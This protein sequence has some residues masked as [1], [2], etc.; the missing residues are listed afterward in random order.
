MVASERLHQAARVLL[1]LACILSGG[2]LL[3]WG[4]SYHHP[5]VVS[6]AQAADHVYF[7]DIHGPRLRLT[8]QTVTVRPG[9]F[10]SIDQAKAY[11]P[12]TQ[13]STPDATKLLTLTIHLPDGTS[14]S[15]AISNPGSRTYERRGL[16][17]NSTN[18]LFEDPRDPLRSYS[19]HMVFIWVP[20]WPLVLLPPM[21]PVAL[22]FWLAY[23]RRT[24]RRAGLCP[25]CG[26]DLRATP[27]PCPECGY[28]DDPAAAAA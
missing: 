16:D 11:V 19:L 6:W 1:V 28:D 14:T 8:Q 7:A 5:L 25:A 21:A 20:L 2:I 9:G 26:Y 24:R 10:T 12:P 17:Q 15:H 18:E 27:Y 4:L 23:R 13:P 3:A 22:F